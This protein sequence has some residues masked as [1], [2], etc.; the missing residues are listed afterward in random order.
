[1]TMMSGSGGVGM[2]GGFERSITPTNWSVASPTD[3]CASTA[4]YE[5]GPCWTMEMDGNDPSSSSSSFP[6]HPDAIDVNQYFNNSM[7]G[8]STDANYD[9]DS[10]NNAASLIA[11]VPGSA[12]S[13]PFQ[14]LNNPHAQFPHPLAQHP[15]TLASAP[16][17]NPINSSGGINSNN[18]SSSGSFGSRF[19]FQ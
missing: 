11:P 17:S 13:S 16:V 2:G 3:S 14:G 8:G 10:S 5:M 1:M 4:D 6:L 18:S 9:S 15:S 19:P 12:S 7:D